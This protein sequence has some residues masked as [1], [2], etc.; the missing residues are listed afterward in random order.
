MA[1]KDRARSVDLAG[2]PLVLDL[3]LY[4]YVEMTSKQEELAEHIGELLL[5][6]LPDLNI[7]AALVPGPAGDVQV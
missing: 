4:I 6:V 3:L 2:E 7:R 5:E 1:A